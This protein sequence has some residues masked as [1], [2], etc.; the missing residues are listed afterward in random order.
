MFK[1]F[2]LYIYVMKSAKKKPMVYRLNVINLGS[3]IKNECKTHNNFDNKRDIIIGEKDI[4]IKINAIND[5]NFESFFDTLEK[6]KNSWDIC[7][8]NG[9]T[10]FKIDL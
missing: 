3:T 1:S 8:I 2:N 5:S 6:Q 9:K 10:Y 7:K 4:L